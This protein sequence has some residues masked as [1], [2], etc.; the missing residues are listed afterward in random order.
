MAADSFQAFHGYPCD[1][2]HHLRLW[3]KG[4]RGKRVPSGDRR[5]ELRQTLA[6]FEISLVFC[7]TLTF[8]QVLGSVSYLSVFM[9][10]NKCFKL[11]YHL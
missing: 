8:T 5:H 1:K 6:E 9:L 2:P 4:K 10:I 3:P 11:F 7:F